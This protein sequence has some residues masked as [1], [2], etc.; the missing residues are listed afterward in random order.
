MSH[1]FDTMSELLQAMNLLKKVFD[2]YAG[3]DGDCKSLS[4]GELGDLLSNELCGGKAMKEKDVE[5]FFADLNNDKD[6]VIDFQE[7][8]TF[9][10][11]LTAL[12]NEHA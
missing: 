6:A 11:A 4:K 12:C 1:H 3:K 10:A 9:V 2:K 5:R 7:Y 8:V